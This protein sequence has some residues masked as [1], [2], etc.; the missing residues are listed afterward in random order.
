MEVA[1]VLHAAGVTA[2]TTVCGDWREGE[3]VLLSGQKIALKVELRRL[4]REHQREVDRRRLAEHVAIAALLQDPRQRMLLL[5]AAHSRVERWERERLCSR[6][7]IEAWRELLASG[8]GVLC[9]R[10]GEDSEQ[11]RALRQNSPFIPLPDL[12]N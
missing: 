11:A 8:L 6:Y 2:D 10:L 4:A 5:D 7:Y 9:A 3:H 1:G 12:G